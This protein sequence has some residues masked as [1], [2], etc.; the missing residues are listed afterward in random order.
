MLSLR[1]RKRLRYGFVLC[2]ENLRFSINVQ[3]G[4]GTSY[5]DSGFVRQ[6]A[7]KWAFFMANSH[8]R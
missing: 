2:I 5:I 1:G 4:V 7:Q 6:K 3:A 8:P